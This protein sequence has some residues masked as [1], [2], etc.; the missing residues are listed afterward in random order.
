MQ[1]FRVLFCVLNTK[2]IPYHRTPLIL[3]LFFRGCDASKARTPQLAAGAWPARLPIQASCRCVASQAHLLP[4]DEVSNAVVELLSD[5]VESA[6]RRLS[7]TALE[8]LAK[9]MQ[10][11]LKHGNF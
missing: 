9:H 3:R 8:S 6:I 11:A 7:D 10:E 1:C 4:G 5:D 2:N